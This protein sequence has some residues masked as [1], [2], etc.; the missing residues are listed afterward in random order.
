MLYG[1][2]LFSALRRAGF[3]V[4]EVY[5]FAIARALLPKHPHKSTAEGYGL[6]LRAVASHTGWEP[7]EI[8]PRLRARWVAPSMTG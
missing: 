6:Q 5:P 1:F 8:E 7:S 2:E 4:I 3:D